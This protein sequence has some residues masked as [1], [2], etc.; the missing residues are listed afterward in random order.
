M[1]RLLSL[2][3]LAL[4]V[5]KTPCIVLLFFYQSQSKRRNNTSEFQNIFEPPFFQSITKMMHQKK[6][7]RK[8]KCLQKLRSWRQNQRKTRHTQ[9]NFQILPC[10]T[11]TIATISSYFKSL[12]EV[13]TT[14][15]KV[16]QMAFCL[17]LYQFYG[18]RKSFK[19]SHFLTIWY[20][21]NAQRNHFVGLNFV[22]FSCDV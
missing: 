5:S 12:T 22:W 14:S 19:K 13:R 20:G 11:T 4:R 15:K 3:L 10:Q 2:M 17:Y 6:R 7:E 21:P 18:V 1:H 9:H 8:K 16:D